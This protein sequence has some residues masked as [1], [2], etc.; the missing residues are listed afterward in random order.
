LHISN[1]SRHNSKVHIIKYYTPQVCIAQ[2]FTVL[3]IYNFGYQT[4]SGRSQSGFAS[5]ILML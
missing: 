1:I 4:A 3:R 5:F 2:G